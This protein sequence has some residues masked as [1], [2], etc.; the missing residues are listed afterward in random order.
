MSRT[1]KEETIVISVAWKIQPAM[2]AEV[3]YMQKDPTVVGVNGKQKATF[4][5]KGVF[6]C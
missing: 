5:G 1:K 6:Y 3:L 2:L 4:W